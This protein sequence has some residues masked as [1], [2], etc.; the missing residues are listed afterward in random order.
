MAEESFMLDIPKLD[1]IVLD[2]KLPV[3][4]SGYN[5]RRKLRLISKLLLL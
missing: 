2:T 3:N 4:I 1:L 5:A